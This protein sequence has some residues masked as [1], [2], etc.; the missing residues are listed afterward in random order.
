LTGIRHISSDS[1]ERIYGLD[2][3][4]Y[5]VGNALR[6]HPNATERVGAQ[7]VKSLYKMQFQ[8][9]KLQD[10]VVERAMQIAY[11][12][13]VTFYDAA[14]LALAIERDSKLIT[15]DERL[16]RGLKKHMEHTVLLDDYPS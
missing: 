8:L 10:R 11:S 12:E 2:L 9:E 15:A 7:A 5:E 13:A 3:I 16:A 1:I 4:V 6:F 14:Y